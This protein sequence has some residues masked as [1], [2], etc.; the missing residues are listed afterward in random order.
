M[1][2]LLSK[3]DARTKLAG[4]NKLEILMFTLGMDQRTQRR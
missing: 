3:V 2:D 1:S 4:T